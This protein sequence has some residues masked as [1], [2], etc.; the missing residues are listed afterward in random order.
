MPTGCCLGLDASWQE[1]GGDV[2]S[3]LPNP[4]RLS[5]T[6]ELIRQ[7]GQQGLPQNVVYVGDSRRRM[8]G[9]LLGPAVAR[10]GGVL[11]PVAGASDA[12]ARAAIGQLRLAAGVDRFVH[13][14]VGANKSAQRRPAR[15]R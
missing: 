13:A 2:F 4:T 15:R 1:V 8:V 12:A 10:L 6:S 3:R 7:G 11:L 9:A 5:T 14:S